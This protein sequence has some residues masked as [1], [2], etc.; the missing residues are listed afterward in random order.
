MSKKNVKI[1]LLALILFVIVAPKTQADEIKIDSYQPRYIVDMPSA[2][3]LDN[4]QYS[5]D[6]LLVGN[7]GFLVDVTVGI[8]KIVNVSMSYGGTGVIGN[9]TMNLQKYPGFHLKTKL[10]QEKETVPAIAIGFNSQG[11]GIYYKR[12]DDMSDDRHEQL[13]PDFYLAASKSFKW[14]VGSLALS[15][16]V[17]YSLLVPDDKGINVYAGIEQSILNVC[18]IALEINPNLND[19]NKM[20]WKDGKTLMLNGALKFT[21]LED[22][23][24]E[25]QI[26]DIFR[27]AHHSTEIGRYF[28]VTFISNLF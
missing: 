20:I 6:A 5:V 23:I 27:N 24:I 15:A 2:G 22:M 4:L 18:A 11:K 8:F 17:N 28:G 13:A 9:S 19:K 16:G 12:N 21:P 14:P 10:L 26:K 25:V 1:I 7:G 3:T